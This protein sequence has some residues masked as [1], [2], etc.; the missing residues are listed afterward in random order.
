MEGNGSSGSFA[1]NVF[2]DE[3]YF[4]ALFDEDEIF[5]ISDEKYAEQIQLQEALMSSV[6]NMSTTTFTHNN[7][8]ED[9]MIDVINNN[10]VEYPSG[11]GKAKLHI[12]ESSGN[13]NNIIMSFCNICMEDKP[14]EKMFTN[15][16]SCN[17]IFCSN[18]MESYVASK[19]QENISMVKCPD[20][21]VGEL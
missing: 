8:C 18:C 6:M 17:H 16:K 4:S 9:E 3:F 15:N 1:G 10:Y 14:I 2:V 19:L 12:G 21:N 5:P 13:S 11:K 7:N 20:P